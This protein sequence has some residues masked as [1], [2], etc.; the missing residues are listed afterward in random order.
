ML[1]SSL[2][3]L[4]TESKDKTEHF[5]QTKLP[6]VTLKSKDQ[7]EERKH[8]SECDMST[9][10]DKELSQIVKLSKKS[11]GIQKTKKK[12]SFRKDCSVDSLI[13]RVACL[14]VSEPVG[15]SHVSSFFFLRETYESEL[16]LLGKE[17][18]RFFK[19]HELAK[20]EIFT[21]NHHCIMIGLVH[22]CASQANILS[23]HPSSLFKTEFGA[24]L[25]SK[26]LKGNFKVFFDIQRVAKVKELVNY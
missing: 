18:S 26:K 14:T 11:K 7:S 20:I 4:V 3:K 17:V 25:Y 5:V 12:S 21:S 8:E 23:K 6:F 22:H 16:E 13:E 2:E 24:L 1:T 15:S 9:D 19:A 10:S